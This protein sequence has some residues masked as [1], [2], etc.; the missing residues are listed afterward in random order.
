M[1]RFGKLRKCTMVVGFDDSI[2][3]LDFPDGGRVPMSVILRNKALDVMAKFTKENY[4]CSGWDAIGVGQNL[5]VLEIFGYKTSAA[6]NVLIS[7]SNYFLETYGKDGGRHAD[8]SVKI[9][10]KLL[11]E[12]GCNAN[13]LIKEK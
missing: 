3:G 7:W 13:R 5:R 9:L 6:D 4:L 10:V 8:N 2:I 1:K 12:K 11:A